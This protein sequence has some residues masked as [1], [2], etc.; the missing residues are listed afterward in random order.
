MTHLSDTVIEQLRESARTMETGKL[1][2]NL[3]ADLMMFLG[4][5][6]RR[7]EKLKKEVASR[8]LFDRLNNNAAMIRKVEE[9]L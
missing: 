8:E 9:L 2:P 4:I 3:R 1:P 7:H 5:L 6:K